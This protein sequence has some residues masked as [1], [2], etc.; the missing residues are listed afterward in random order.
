MTTPKVTK[1][2]QLNLKTVTW[3]ELTWVNIEKP[4]ERRQNTWLSIIPSITWI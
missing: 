4:T 3:G 1:E 2:E